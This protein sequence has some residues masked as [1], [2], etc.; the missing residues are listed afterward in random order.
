[1]SYEDAITQ[2]KSQPLTTPDFSGLE[3]RIGERRDAR[4]GADKTA[5]INARRWLCVAFMAFVILPAD[6]FLQ[7][8]AMESEPSVQGVAIAVMLPMAMLAWATRLVTRP[9]FGAQVLV[10]SIAVSNLVVALLLAISVG[11]I[12]G[13]VSQVVI[14]FSC[15]RVLKLLGDR[16]LDASDE[17]STFT[18]VAFRGF[19]ILALIMAF[20]D[21]QTLMFSA[22]TQGSYL[23][24]DGRTLEI[25]TAMVPTLLAAGIMVLNVWGLF[26]LRTWAMLLNIAANLVIARM[27]LTGGLSVNDP[28]AASLTST[29]VVQLML[30]VPILATWLGDQNAGSRGW[31]RGAALVRM[32][33]PA[34]VVLTIL[35]AV[36]NLGFA[37]MWGWLDGNVGAT[38]Q[39]RGL[40]ASA[41][42]RPLEREGFTAQIEQGSVVWGVAAPT[43]DYG[44]LMRPD[45]TFAFVHMTDCDMSGADAS[46]LF[47][48]D[49]NFRR[50]D[51]SEAK[52]Q[53]SMFVG[54]KL[55]GA[56]FREA[57]L[58]GALFAGCHL[59]EVDWLGATCPD[60]FI[61]TADEGCLP[62]LGHSRRVEAQDVARPMG[63][64]WLGCTLS[65][66]SN[67]EC[68]AIARWASTDLVQRGDDLVVEWG[69]KRERRELLLERD[70]GTS[71]VD[72]TGAV[73]M[74]AAPTPEGEVELFVS[75]GFGVRTRW[76]EKVNPEQRWRAKLRNFGFRPLWR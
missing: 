28:V 64:A 10:R 75:S 11:G 66:G 21:A 13:A 74:V 47:V 59:D 32:C 63:Q 46:G 44:A 4:V 29:A 68:S 42:S 3:A 57:N 55:V 20:A 43:V 58:E 76:I 1:M 2:A 54:A 36:S 38:A 5:R 19:L 56:S 25:A 69:P 45:L 70:T 26:R 72:A 39:Q 53:R 50:T 65:G 24:T 51:F 9:S 71:W 41:N 61:A 7:A 37:R 22:M 73:L 30:P 31:P 16:G 17:H 49:G 27:A 15:Y 48:K 60:G 35:F 12:V 23:L 52:L 62:H 6:I 40:A 34:A 8:W 14:A 18:P 33:I 67:D